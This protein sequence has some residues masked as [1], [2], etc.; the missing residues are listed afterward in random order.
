MNDTESDVNDLRKE[1][2]NLQQ[3]IN[4]IISTYNTRF[5]QLKNDLLDLQ[6]TV[7]ML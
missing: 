7:Y 5:E 3:Q 2:V 6:E 4:D 1:I